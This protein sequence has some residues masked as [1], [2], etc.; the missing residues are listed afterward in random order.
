MIFMPD[1]D[2]PP[3]TLWPLAMNVPS[4]GDFQN[5]KTIRSLYQNCQIGG[6]GGISDGLPPFV[7]PERPRVVL[8]SGM[9]YCSP[10]WNSLV[11]GF[12]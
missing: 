6:A 10:G 3:A 8:F 12:R 9:E 4:Y 7:G 2:T 1:I 5:S 11:L